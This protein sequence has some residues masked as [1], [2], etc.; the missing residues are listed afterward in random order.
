MSVNGTLHGETP[1]WLSDDVIH[2]F[3][4]NYASIHSSAVKEWCAALHSVTHKVLHRS[5]SSPELQTGA[6]VHM[7]S[8][9]VDDGTEEW[10]KQRIHKPKTRYPFL[11]NIV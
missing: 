10:E 3:L 4:I 9:G 5:P 8:N 7:H 6:F 2:Y 11:S 1:L